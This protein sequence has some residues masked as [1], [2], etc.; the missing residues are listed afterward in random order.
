[1]VSAL[2][3]FA[4]LP[5]LGGGEMLL[6]LFVVLMLFGGEKMPQLAKGIGKSLREFKKAAV[7]V[8]KEIKRAIDEVPDTPKVEVPSV[9][10][11][12][13]EIPKTFPTHPPARS[14]ATTKSTPPAPPTSPPSAPETG[15]TPQT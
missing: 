2:H 13:M 3:A 11:P 5:D 1:M 6:L 15:A 12:S 14:T 9:K 10:L 4:F 7:E 8:E